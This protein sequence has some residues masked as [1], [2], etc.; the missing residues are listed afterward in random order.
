MNIHEYQEIWTPE[1][2]DEYYMTYYMLL[3]IT[4]S[5]FLVVISYQ[6]ISYVTISLGKIICWPLNEGKKPYK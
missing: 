2:G 6:L 1:I 3:Y 4:C 5:C